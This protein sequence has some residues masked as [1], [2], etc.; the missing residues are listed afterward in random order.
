MRVPGRFVKGLSFLP[1]LPNAVTSTVEDRGGAVLRDYETPVAPSRR[2]FRAAAQHEAER[3]QPLV[4][5]TGYTFIGHTSD[6]GRV[7]AKPIGE[8]GE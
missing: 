2:D 1:A 6:D 5:L 7:W 8:S 4:D 3:I